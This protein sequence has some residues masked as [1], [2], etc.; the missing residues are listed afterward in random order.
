MIEI[1]QFY[2]IWICGRAQCYQNVYKVSKCLTGLIKRYGTTHFLLDGL[3]CNLQDTLEVLCLT[4][5]QNLKE[6]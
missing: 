6:F 2:K 5:P 4:F 1:T 3:S